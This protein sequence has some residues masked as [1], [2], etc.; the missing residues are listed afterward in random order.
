MTIESA[1]ANVQAKVGVAARHLE[2]DEEVLHQAADLFFTASTFKVPL[3]VELYRQVDSGT[4]DMNSRIELTDRLR[5][6]GS[7]VLKELANGLSLTVHDLAVLMIIISDNT[8]T[9][10]LYDLIDRRCLNQT[11]QELGLTSTRIPMSCR[12]LLYSMYGI[13]T[14]NIAEAAT[15][16]SDRLAKSQVVEDSEGA[17]L[18]NSNVSSPSD[19]VGL[20][21][22]LY[23]DD[24]LSSS[25]RHAALDILGRQQHNTIIPHYLPPGTKTA[26]KTGGVTGVRCDV[27]IVYAPSGSYTVALMAREVADRSKIDRQLAGVSRA[28]YEHFEGSTMASGFV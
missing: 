17:S 1:I 13:H 22:M 23:R 14:H 10:M 20:L 16:V 18:D 21:G 15:Q 27:G 5:A 3:L 26:H 24:I 25:S 11:M 8:A 19:M 28:L 4:V 6:P 7:G 9:D 12:E 2:T